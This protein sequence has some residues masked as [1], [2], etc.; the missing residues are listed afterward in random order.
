MITGQSLGGCSGRSGPK[1]GGWNE[2]GNSLRLFEEGM[3]E[4]S[5]MLN[6]LVTAGDDDSHV[7]ISH[8]NFD[9]HLIDKLIDLIR[10]HD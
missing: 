2:R 5:K 8:V 1:G 6:F 10:W 3:L 7:T 9:D 4:Q